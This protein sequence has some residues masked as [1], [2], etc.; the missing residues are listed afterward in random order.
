MS[1]FLTIKEVLKNLNSETKLKDYGLSF[2]PFFIRVGNDKKTLSLITVSIEY[3]KPANTVVLKDVFELDIFDGKIKTRTPAQRYYTTLSKEL[4]DVYNCLRSNV[5]KEIYAEY[6][7]KSN[8]LLDKI[9]TDVSQY[10]SIYV[11]DYITYLKYVLYPYTDILADTF[12]K[13]SRTLHFEKESKVTCNNCGAVLKVNTSSCQDGAKI[14]VTCNKC[15]NVI[16]SV[17]NKK[18]QIVT[19]EKLYEKVREEESTANKAAEQTEEKR[20]AQI[21]DKEASYTVSTEATLNA[22]ESPQIKEIT[23][24][25]ITEVEIVGE[26]TETEPVAEEP[27]PEEE[28]EIEVEVTAEP[29]VEV[30]EVTEVIEVTEVTES[31]EEPVKEEPTVTKPEAIPVSETLSALVSELPAEFEEDINEE[32]E[33]GNIEQ[34]YDAEVIEALRKKKE[35]AAI[36]KKAEEMPR[37]QTPSADS[38]DIIGLG[39]QK[40]AFP[41][42]KDI[43]KS[44]APFNHVFGLKGNVGSGIDFSLR[45]MGGYSPEY[46]NNKTEFRPFTKCVVIDISDGYLEDWIRERIVYMRKFEGQIFFLRGNPG[47]WEQFLKNEPILASYITEIISYKG[48]SKEELYS[49]YTK[50]LGQYGMKLADI[51]DETKN[52]VFGSKEINAL[53]VTKLAA[54]TYFRA[55]AYG[56]YVVEESELLKAFNQP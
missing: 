18:I 1:N 48:Y 26:T 49:I 4:E 40:K 2:S 33:E 52:T 23:A 19:Y 11:E 44:N 22:Q 32:A 28:V 38:K 13:L 16:K 39:Y 50:R 25:E 46:V 24:E 31:V 42:I 56:G 53:K 7:N 15:K 36:N 8:E 17:Y 21:I 20:D 35:E 41:V 43:M 12:V 9:R 29:V 37:T 5:S 14:S 27:T 30:E 51:S 54:R 34:M 47:Q 55:K 45:T 3:N 10:M 6:R